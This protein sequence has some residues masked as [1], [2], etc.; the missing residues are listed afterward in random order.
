[1]LFRRKP[2]PMD[3]SRTLFSDS[4]TARAAQRTVDFEAPT[5]AGHALRLRF[6]VNPGAL[7]EPVTVLFVPL[8]QLLLARSKLKCVQQGEVRALTIGALCSER[9]SMG[10]PSKEVTLHAAWS[11]ELFDWHNNFREFYWDFH[12]PYAY[13]AVIDST[14]PAICDL[15]IARV[16]REGW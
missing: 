10:S 12:G 8:S 15:K 5:T 14:G 13:R 7:L 11:C 4:S 16:S 9:A 3:G 6:S 2:R 1:M